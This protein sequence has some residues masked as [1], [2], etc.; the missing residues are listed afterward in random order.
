MF[1][2]IHCGSTIIGDLWKAIKDVYLDPHLVG[3]ILSQ[4]I[5]EL[6]DVSLQGYNSVIHLFQ[7]L[8]FFKPKTSFQFGTEI[9]E[10]DDFFIK[11]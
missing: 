4:N 8:G 9:R 7:G 5:F 3:S 6:I 2:F 10:N 1:L 11:M